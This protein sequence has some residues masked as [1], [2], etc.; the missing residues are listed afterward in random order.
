V[1]KQHAMMADHN[2]EKSLFLLRSSH[3]GQSENVISAGE[4]QVF[5]ILIEGPQHVKDL[6]VLLDCKLFSSSH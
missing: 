2:P 1:L 5:N 3:T 4:A 6:G